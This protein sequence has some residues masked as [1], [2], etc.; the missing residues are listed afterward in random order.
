MIK[1]SYLTMPRPRT[2]IIKQGER[3]GR[4][5]A[6]FE[7]ESYTTP[8]G[9]IKRRFQC[10]C[11]CG[12]VIIA[13]S[14]ELKNKDTKSC[15]CQKIDSTIKRNTKHGYSVRLNK[16]SEYNIWKGIKARCNN[17]NKKC[18][19]DYGGRGI[20]LCDEWFNDFESFYN[21]IGPRPSMSHSVDRIDNDG[22]YEPGNVRWAT[23][24]EQANNKR[25]SKNE[26]I[27]YKT[28]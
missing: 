12:N 18:W 21:H 27:K 4:L 15:G 11:D 5:T 8:G 13:R 24:K 14:G 6:Q 16:Y 19:K 20:K 28:I 1:T 23:I 3:F 10:V 2:E 22:N 9:T 25:T 17:P 26:T 7:V